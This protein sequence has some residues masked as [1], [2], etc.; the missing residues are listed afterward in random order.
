MEVFTL[1]DC[2]NITISYV[3]HYK[4]K[5]IAVAIR[6]NRTCERVLTPDVKRHLSEHEGAQSHISR[7]LYFLWVL[8]DTFFGQLLIRLSWHV[9]SSVHVHVNHVF[10]TSVSEGVFCHK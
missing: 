2:D 4:Q 5:E 8:F 7:E 6:I 9:Y 10:K 3:A 1:C